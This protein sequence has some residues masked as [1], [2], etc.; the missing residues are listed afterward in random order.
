[1]QPTQFKNLEDKLARSG[2]PIKLMR[3]VNARTYP[4]PYRVDHT[5]WADE[6]LAWRE[7]ATMFD[8]SD[9]M[10]EYYFEGPDAI[11]LCSDICINSLQNFGP[12]RA[13]HIVCVNE[14]GFYIG[15]SILSYYAEN[16]IG[17]CGV[18][19]MLNWATYIAQKNK[20]DVQIVIDPPTLWNPGKRRFFHYQLNGPLS[21]RI[22]EKAHGGPIE[23]IKF[24][25][26]G[27]VTLAGCEL[28]VLNHTMSGKAGDEM[29][30]FELY[31]AVDY[32]KQVYEAL[33]AAGEEFGMR[34][35]G[36]RAYPS[37]SYEGGWSPL[38]VPA[39]YSP[40][41]KEYREWLPAEKM[42]GNVPLVGSF[43]SPHVEDYYFTPWALGYHRLINYDHDFIGREALQEMAK[44]PQWR[45][46]WLHWDNKDALRLIEQ[47]LFGGANRTKIVDL[48]NA[49]QNVTTYDEVRVNGRHVGFGT[50][51]GYTVNIGGFVTLG[52][53]SPEVDDGDEVTIT[54]G[55]PPET[56]PRYGMV[57][58]V[59][60]TLKAR[61]SSNPPLKALGA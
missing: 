36:A 40:K 50:L 12:G 57:P 30:G 41:M 11:K 53:V 59:Q 2:G 16:K 43:N 28:Y 52:M 39:I 54:W 35:G 25:H 7:T 15:D 6:Q 24:F 31:G 45:K 3:G 46:V 29:T 18:T 32:K 17:M 19:Y 20:Y 60:T 14:D 49:N 51:A 33:C 5:S 37:A 38:M 4:F 23:R 42:E 1:M 22:L 44:A 55:E 34:L 10:P 9:H 8:Q 21:Q 48:P 27:R 56:L 58:H 13:K 47:G 61:V 26:M